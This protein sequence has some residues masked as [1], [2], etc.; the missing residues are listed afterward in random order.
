[1]FFNKDIIELAKQNTYFRQVLFTTHNSQVV[2][3]SI[4]PLGEIGEEIHKVD[5]ILIF[6]QGEGSGL[7]TSPAPISTKI[8]PLPSTTTP[9]H[10]NSIPKS[11]N[12]AWNAGTLA[13][14]ASYARAHPRPAA[15]RRCAPSTPPALLSATGP[16]LEAF[17]WTTF[18]SGPGLHRSNLR[19]SR[20]VVLQSGLR[21]GRWCSA[22]RSASPVRP[23][24]SGNPR[25]TPAQS[26][27]KAA[28]PWSSVRRLA[29]PQNGENVSS[30]SSV[31]TTRSSR[32]FK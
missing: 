4:P 26:H 9:S 10:C 12:P 31:I 3:M 30:L 29:Q 23:R 6:V 5:Q 25:A 19:A 15:S 24:R 14:P 1:M 7:S 22:L 13:T 27:P 11:R 18:C 16:I 32:A 21:E 28:R 17:G 8:K 20:A 2:V